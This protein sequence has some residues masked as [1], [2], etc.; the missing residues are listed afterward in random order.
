[1]GPACSAGR[2]KARVVAYFNS[3][4]QVLASDASWQACAVSTCVKSGRRVD[5]ESLRGAF[6]QRSPIDSEIARYLRKR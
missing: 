5:V 3:R 1:M 6:G 4:P 2:F